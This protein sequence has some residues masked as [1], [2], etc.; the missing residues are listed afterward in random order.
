METDLEGILSSWRPIWKEDCRAGSMGTSRLEVLTE[1]SE[2]RMGGSENKQ[3]CHWWHTA[4]RE[5]LPETEP[6]PRDQ[7]SLR[8]GRFCF[9]LRWASEGS[10]HEHWESG[11]LSTSSGS[12][13]N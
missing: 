9:W 8:R 11:D 5:G 7:F 1:V 2:D 13:T 6:L 4:L 12:S 10:G 3:T